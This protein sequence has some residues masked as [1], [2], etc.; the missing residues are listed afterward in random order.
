MT[1]V[2][3][4]TATKKAVTKTVKKAVKKA[5]TKPAEAARIGEIRIA[6]DGGRWTLLLESG[7][8]VAVAAAAA[9]AAGVRIGARWTEAL[10]TR[11]A[12]ASEEQR[13]VTRAMGLLAKGFAGDRAALC[14]A[15]GGDAAAMRAVRSLAENGW[16]S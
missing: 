10:A 4:K 9:Q 3:K 13:L 6:K 11:V 5:A 7:A 12:R 15:L 14:E 2:V 8:R 1:R 16:I